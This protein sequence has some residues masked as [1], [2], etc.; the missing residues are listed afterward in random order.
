MENIL[1]GLDDLLKDYAKVIEV[2][3]KKELDWTTNLKN[4][5]KVE[6]EENTITV[7]TPLYGW[8]IDS[9]RRPGAKMPPP[10]A[11]YGWLEKR[12]IPLEA[13][14]PIARSIGKKGIMP[15][16]WLYKAIDLESLASEIALLIASNIEKSFSEKNS[17]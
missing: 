13:A 2:N 16:P 14:Y 11:L 6:G 9:G 1:S 3:I 7:F 10:S 5:I 17:E 15:R 4:E 12:S 8:V